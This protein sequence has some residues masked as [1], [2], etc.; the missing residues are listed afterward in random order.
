[1]SDSREAWTGSF[2]SWLQ[3]REGKNYQQR[4]QREAYFAGWSARDAEVE[5]WKALSVKMYEDHNEMAEENEK[6]EVEIEALKARVEELED[7]L[8]RYV[9]EVPGG[10]VVVFE[11]DLNKDTFYAAKEWAEF[12]A[13][14]QPGEVFVICAAVEKVVKESSDEHL[15]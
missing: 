15:G 6:L 10:Y 5:K 9:T 4:E 7:R 8:R 11:S 1:M 14:D 12:C 13:N 2:G 3:Q